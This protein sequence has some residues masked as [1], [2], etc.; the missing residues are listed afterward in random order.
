MLNDTIE[1]NK[2]MHDNYDNQSS[3]HN[4]L[5]DLE[6][7]Y[8]GSRTNSYNMVDRNG[9]MSSDKQKFKNSLIQHDGSSDVQRNQSFSS[10][11]YQYDDVMRQQSFQSQ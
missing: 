10:Q 11:Q 2:N 9:S 4:E 8:S 1:M 7:Q 6:N 5:G 3:S